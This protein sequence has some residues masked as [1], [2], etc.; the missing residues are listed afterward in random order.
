MYYLTEDTEDTCTCSCS[1]IENRVLP[2]FYYFLFYREVSEVRT[3]NIVKSAVDETDSG[4]KKKKTHNAHGC[5]Y[6][7]ICSRD[8]P[9]TWGPSAFSKAK[10]PL[11]IMVQLSLDYPNP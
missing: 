11:Q 8:S 4:G 1:K 2:L 10:H 5:S 9:P 7:E 3:K 6:E